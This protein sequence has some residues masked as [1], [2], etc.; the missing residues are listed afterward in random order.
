MMLKEEISSSVVV[1]L[2]S[3][4]ELFYSVYLYFTRIHM[5]S[6]HVKTTFA[7]VTSYCMIKKLANVVM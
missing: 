3:N 4:S 2:T 7:A 6:A 1:A 5:T